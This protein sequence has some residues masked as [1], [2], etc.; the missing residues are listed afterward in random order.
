L[1]EA[2]WN[3]AVQF[4]RD[5]SA[6]SLRL[7]DDRQADPFAAC[8]R[9]RDALFSRSSIFSAPA[10]CPPISYSMISSA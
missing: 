7:D 6:A 2:V 5:F 4:N 1:P 9:C 3:V 8:V 10:G